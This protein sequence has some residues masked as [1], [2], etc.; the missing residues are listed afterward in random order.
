MNDI[1]RTI[2][3]VIFGFSMVLLWDQWQAGHLFPEP[4]WQAS[5]HSGA[6]SRFGR[7]CGAGNWRA[8]ASRSSRSSWTGPVNRANKPN[9]GP[10]HTA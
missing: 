8:P 10:C 4:G 1:R 6:T 7:Q 2:L 3:W 5:R 9:A